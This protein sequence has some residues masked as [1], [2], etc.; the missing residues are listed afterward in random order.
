MPDRSGL[1]GK[2][3]PCGGDEDS[4]NR[5]LSRDGRI[6][7]ISGNSDSHAVSGFH[8]QRSGGRNLFRRSERAIDPETW[9]FRTWHFANLDGEMVVLDGRAY[10]VQGSG[11][12]SEAASNNREHHFQ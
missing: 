4:R 6:G 12:V 9:G 10:Q 5:L 11:K 3:A 2:R 7:P 1:A 8:F